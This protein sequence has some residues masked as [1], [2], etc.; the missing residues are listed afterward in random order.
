[1]AELRPNAPPSG[2]SGRHF[3][4]RLRDDNPSVRAH[5]LE[6]LRD[7]ASPHVMA[8]TAAPLLADPD[9]GLR[10]RAAHLLSS[11]RDPKAAAAEVAAYI[12]HPNIKTRNLAGEVLV[13][14][15]RPAVGALAP[16]LRDDHHDVRKF[17]IDVLAQ[18]P[19]ASLA[20]AIAAALDDPD[21]NVRLAAIHALG[22]LGASEYSGALRDVYEREPLARPD[23]LHAMGKFGPDADLD[24]LE[25]GL[26]DD[27]PVVQLASAEALASQGAPEVIDLLLNQVDQVD[28]MAR[29]VVLH[30]IV[31]LC[32][33]HPQYQYTLPATLKEAFLDMLS[34]PDPIYR[35]AAAQGLQWFVD[36]AT[37]ASMLAHAGHDDDLDMA[38]FTTLL[39]HPVPFDPLH[40]AATSGQ[41]TTS[42]AAM[43]TVGLL[44]KGGL[45]DDA[46]AQAGC[47]LQ[48]H[49]DALDVDDKV[50]TL[51]LC[52]QLDTAALDGVAHAAL[53]DPHPKVQA[54]AADMAPHSPSSSKDHSAL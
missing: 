36:D 9:P 10:E 2:S 45:A 16:Y 11:L 47:F 12:A 44:A 30:S 54:L 34:D 24:L 18:L 51:G 27:R 40:Q 53:A 38:L 29:P 13:D 7:K 28:P 4:E 1:M 19:A 22:A 33:N 23:I 42:A 37:Y 20:D 5:A 35:C 3:D 46:L 48:Q 6:D 50:T 15:G 25:R 31:E 43:F 8:R 39:Q 49:F 17:A 26:Q 41:M 52:Q 14:L 32:T 21:A